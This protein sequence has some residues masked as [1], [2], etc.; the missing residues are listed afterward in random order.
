MSKLAG[1][2][3]Q[4]PQAVCPTNCGACCGVIF[5]SLAELRAVKEWCE[6]HHREYKD[7]TMIVGLD[8]PYLNEKKA[9]AIY[10][11]RPFLCRIVGASSD[12]PCPIKKCESLRMLNHAQSNKLYKDIY[13]R[14]KEKPRTE[15][16]RR[17]IRELL[18]R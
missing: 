8:C 1:I 5:P 13:L 7:F 16:H 6:N 3:R 17:L 4:I 10:P 2:Y 12:I 9:C 14:G 15:K 11:V 18:F